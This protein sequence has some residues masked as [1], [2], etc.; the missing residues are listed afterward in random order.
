M[1]RYCSTTLVVEHSLYLERFSVV[2]VGVE[3]AIP[4]I[5]NA[6]FS[7]FIFHTLDER[8]QH[9][10]VG[11]EVLVGSYLCIAA[12]ARCYAYLGVVLFHAGIEELAQHAGAIVRSE[13]RTYRKVYDHWLAGIVGIA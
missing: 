1:F 10:V 7:H 3:D 12:I 13:L 4:Y 9:R 8:P 11:S 2:A 6:V 5:N